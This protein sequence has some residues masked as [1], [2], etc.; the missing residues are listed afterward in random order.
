MPSSWPRHA[1]RSRRRPKYPAPERLGPSLTWTDGSGGRVALPAGVGT[2]GPVRDVEHDPD[3]DEEPAPAG[4]ADDGAPRED[5]EQRRVG[6]EDQAQQ[7]Q[8]EPVERPVHQRGEDPDQQQ[9][10]PW[11]EP[12]Q[13]REQA[14]HALPPPYR[15]SPT[16]AR[17]A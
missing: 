13:Q 1:P 10:D 4:H 3:H 15:P 16:R 14:P 6:Q 5:V 12:R 7:R 9:R 17:E 8:D 11:K 2:A